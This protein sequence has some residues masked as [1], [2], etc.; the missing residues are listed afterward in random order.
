[1]GVVAL[2]DPS[3]EYL[4]S[5]LGSHCL[6]ILK[7]NGL[8]CRFTLYQATVKAAVMFIQADVPRFRAFYTAMSSEPLDESAGAR[9]PGLGDSAKSQTGPT[10]RRVRVFRW[11]PKPPR[12]ATAKAKLRHARL[13]K[14]GIRA[15]TPD[16]CVIVGASRTP[17]PS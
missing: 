11:P 8:N 13:L 9:Q 16:R 14:P 4:G 2:V 3:D 6:N 7:C 5:I 15:A 10:R 17:A 12:D 1:M